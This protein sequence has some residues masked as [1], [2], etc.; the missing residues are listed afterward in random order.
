M[1]IEYMFMGKKSEDRTPHKKDIAKSFENCFENV[2]KNTFTIKPKNKIYTI[3]YSA[4]SCPAEGT[5]DKYSVYEVCICMDTEDVAKCAELLDIVNTKLTECP[6]IRKEYNIVITY[7]EMSGYYSKKI[8]PSFY[9]F[10]SKLRCLVYKIL[11]KTFG[12]TWIE[13]AMPENIRNEIKGKLKG[14]EGSD[15]DGR[16]IEKALDEMTYYELDAFLFSE[17][18]GTD[19]EEFL[20]SVETKENLDALT[21]EQIIELITSNQKKSIW[22]KFFKDKVQMDDLRDNLEELRQE[23]NKVAHCKKFTKA[24]Y[25]KNEKLLNKMIE[26]LD[27]A[28]AS[29]LIIEPDSDAF[30]DIVKAFLGILLVGAVVAVKAMDGISGMLKKVSEVSKDKNI[31]DGVTSFVKTYAEVTGKTHLLPQSSE[32]PKTGSD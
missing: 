14:S 13:Q 22:D 21:K 17:N 9:T 7:N 6:N 11:I 29:N 1:R 18:R 3:Q 27:I 15:S 20:H 4:N 10:E 26:S 28:L 5:T 12:R 16:L 25:E 8:Y 32:L 19:A 2:T 31:S 30:E 23:R 24:D